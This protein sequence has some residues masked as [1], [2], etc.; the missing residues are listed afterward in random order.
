MRTFATRP[1]PRGSIHLVL[2]DM[3]HGRLPVG[4]PPTTTPESLLHHDTVTNSQGQAINTK[5]CCF[6]SS[7]SPPFLASFIRDEP[8]TQT[9]FEVVADVAARGQLVCGDQPSPDTRA[10]V[11]SSSCCCPWLTPL[12]MVAYMCSARIPRTSSYIDYSALPYSQVYVHFPPSPT[13]TSTHVVDSPGLYDRSPIVVAENS[14]AMPR[15]GCPGRTYTPIDG[16]GRGVIGVANS[17][18]LS[19]SKFAIG[20]SPSHHPPPLV[21]D[22]G[23]SSDDSDANYY[24]SP[25]PDATANYLDNGRSLCHPMCTPSQH[26][27]TCRVA[28]SFRSSRET[29]P[30]Q[31]LPHAPVAPPRSPRSSSHSKSHSTSSSGRRPTAA[32]SSSSSWDSSSC[33]EGF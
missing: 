31:F 25:T 21:Q 3:M 2:C 18:A 15:R 16:V 17:L 26:V 28:S 29:D 4:F 23:S 24:P 1:S 13:L 30:T 33:L 9:L 27:P 10:I 5:C 8:R 11:S 32:F 20:P 7:P 12:I 14:C 19:C 22:S 6:S